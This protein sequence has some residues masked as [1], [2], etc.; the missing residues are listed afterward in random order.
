MCRKLVH[1]KHIDLKHLQKNDYE[2][3]NTQGR[4]TKLLKDEGVY[5]ITH[6]ELKAVH[7]LPSTQKVLALKLSDVVATLDPNQKATKQKSQILYAPRV[8]CRVN[9]C[10]DEQVGKVKKSR[11][12]EIKIC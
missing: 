1:G 10:K 9:G 3:K 5:R 2:K 7:G 8:I 12:G 6:T 4:P 11:T